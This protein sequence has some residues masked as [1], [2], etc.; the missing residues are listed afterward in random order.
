MT[1]EVFSDPHL[2]K[3]YLSTTQPHPGAAV[4]VMQ[5]IRSLRPG[6][7]AKLSKRYDEIYNRVGVFTPSKEQNDRFRGANLFLLDI[8]KRF[9]NQG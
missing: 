3:C 5:T 4:W 7:W 8:I 9:G 6:W 1:H 2:P